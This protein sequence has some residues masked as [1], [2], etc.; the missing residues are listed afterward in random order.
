MKRCGKERR[1]LF[2]Q[3]L[4]QVSDSCGKEV[5]RLKSEMCQEK[6]YVKDQL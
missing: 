5:Q 1:L 6:H 2:T 3:K 4:V